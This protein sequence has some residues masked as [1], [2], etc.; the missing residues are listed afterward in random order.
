VLPPWR[1]V[2]RPGLARIRGYPK[3]GCPSLYPRARQAVLHRGR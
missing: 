3:T 2:I 1:S